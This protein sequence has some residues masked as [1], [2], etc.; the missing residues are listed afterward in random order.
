[1]ATNHEFYKM[2]LDIFQLA[3]VRE[4]EKLLAN[5]K[6]TFWKQLSIFTKKISYAKKTT[7]S[8]LALFKSSLSRLYQSWLVVSSCLDPATLHHC[9]SL[10]FLRSYY[11]YP[12][13]ILT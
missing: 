4:F 12:V 13:C 3:T 8:H 11:T 2:K 10:S 1:M 7:F 9:Y 5:D 6:S